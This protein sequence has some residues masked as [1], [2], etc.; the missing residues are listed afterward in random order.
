MN[1]RVYETEYFSSKSVGFIGQLVTGVWN[2]LYFRI[3]E[4]LLHEPQIEVPVDGCVS[5][6]LDDQNLPFRWLAV[7]HVLV[8][9]VHGSAERKG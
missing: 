9:C 3:R 5:C 6:T 8:P 2:K 4:F 7:R 1:V